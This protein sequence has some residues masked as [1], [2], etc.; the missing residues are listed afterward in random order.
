M[1]QVY[2]LLASDLIDDRYREAEASA[3]RHLP[4]VHPGGASA[5]R[6]AARRM[7][8]WALRQIETAAVDVAR[9]AKE[10]ACR[11]ERPAAVPGTVDRAC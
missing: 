11:L 3:R 9:R 1:L 7:R 5:P 10:A 8:A 4:A 6:D 2:T